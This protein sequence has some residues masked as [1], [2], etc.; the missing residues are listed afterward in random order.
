MDNLNDVQSVSAEEYRLL[1][2]KNKVKW[3]TVVMLIAAIA[4]AGMLAI[5]FYPEL[6]RRLLGDQ[7]RGDLSQ[8]TQYESSTT[9]YSGSGTYNLRRVSGT[10]TST[11]YLGIEIQDLD[12]RMSTALNLKSN[13]G[14]VITKVIPSSPAAASGLEAGDIIIRF[15]RIRIR[16]SSQIIEA[17]KDEEPGDVIKI[18][19]DRDGLTRAFY[20]ELGAPGSSFFQRTALTSSDDTISNAQITTQWG[21]TISALSYEL[22]NKLSLPADVKGVV[23]VSVSASGLAKAAGIQAGDLITQVNRQSTETLQDF[24][25]NIQGQPLVV[26]EIYRSGRVLFVRI[27][28]NN[29]LPPVATIA[30]SV[31]DTASTPTNP[32]IDFSTTNLPKRVAIAALGQDLDAMLSPYFGSAPYFIIVDMPSKQYSVVPNTN[33]YADMYGIA[34]VQ[35]L[36]SK[37]VT[38]IIAENYGPS[39]YQSVIIQKLQLF[40]AN[41]GKVSDA[42]EQYESFLLDQV[43][44][45]T[46]LGA[47]RNMVPTGGAPFSSDE[48]DEEEEQSGYKGLPYTI[49]PQGK[50]DPDLDPANQTQTQTTVNPQTAINT[51]LT[52]GSVQGRVAIAAV[53]TD[54]KSGIAPLYGT[55]PYFFLFDT[56]TNQYQIT[57]NPALGAS[58][59]YG[60]ITTQFLQSQ[61]MGAVIAGNFGARA[62]TVLFASNIVPYIFQGSVADGIENFRSGKLRPISDSTLPGYTYSQNVLPTGGSPF[63]SDE[64]DDEEEEQSGYKGMPYTIPPQGKYDPELDPENNVSSQTAQTNNPAIPQLVAIAAT[65]NSLNAYMAQIFRTA[66]YFLIVDIRSNQ[67]SA[68]ANPT[69]T[70]PTIQPSQVVISKGVGA[71][72]AGIYGPV[73]YSNLVANNVVPFTANPGTVSNILQLYKSGQLER[74]SVAATSQPQSQLQT[75]AFVNPTLDPTNNLQPTAGSTQRSDYCYCPY[76]QITVPHP[77]SVPCSALTC[78]QCANRL[79]NYDASG[80]INDQ[81][82]IPILP[83]YQQTVAGI[84]SG[85][86]TYVQLPSTTQQSLGVNL[87]PQTDY[88]QVPSQNQLRT[89]SLTTNTSLLN[90][91]QQTQYCYCPRCNV[92]YEH[93]RGLPCS[94]L[95]C[96]ACGS[97]LISLNGGAINQFQDTQLYN[98]QTVS[99]IVV[100]GQPSTIPPMGQTTAGMPTSGQPSTIPPM[101]QTTAGMPTAGMPT[102][103]M[104]TA[105]FPTIPAAITIAGQPTMIPPA[106]STQ[107]GAMPVTGIID[108]PAMTIAGQRSGNVCIATIGKTIESQVADIFDKAPYFLIVGLGS[109]EVIPNPNVDDYKGSGV[110]SAQLIVSEGARVVL[111]NDIGIRAI[112]E[113]HTLNVQVYTGIRGTAAQ[114]LRWYQDDR[115]TPTVL[116]SN[117]HTDDEEQHGPPTSSK[118]KSKGESTTTSTKTL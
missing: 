88:V 116:N 61:S 108:L 77:S 12:D 71:T 86:S 100:S 8:P 10:T 6:F 46:M 113:L 20:L 39:V 80:A 84:V 40:R 66:P 63:T 44:S 48:D 25:R 69:L 53:G 11:A 97:R 70:N 96:S 30:G 85:S 95:S 74:V 92:V 56:A 87:V 60:T 29:T 75:Q 62:N 117:S 45:S 65:A 38:G 3:M 52:S 16:D 83:Q 43:N 107:V 4:I 36:M 34:A 114:A 98:G 59:S 76:C 33:S 115:L 35:M 22:V 89:G 54:L 9:L 18:V 23:V 17:L 31:D 32:S 21:C 64:D 78:P 118:S 51:Q 101:G 79:M 105:G 91:N 81:S 19:V 109:I 28:Q 7:E 1:A 13:T 106:G 27:E 73:C 90:L 103:G 94:S 57:N 58:R 102:A 37:G 41:P 14:V 93:P 15:D 104:P 42:L 26:L 5:N 110:Q 99:G 2:L 82:I 47:V 112:E 50:Y 72:I 68:I 67:F 24:Y 111:T 49:P 55:A